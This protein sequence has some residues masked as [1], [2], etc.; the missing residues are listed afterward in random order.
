VQKCGA[1][2][3]SSA[4]GEGRSASHTRRHEQDGVSRRTRNNDRRASQ[5]ADWRTIGSKKTVAKIEAFPIR[6]GYIAS[7]GS[8]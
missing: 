7:I 5:L 3:I 6:K 2:E 4:N 8:G 1:P